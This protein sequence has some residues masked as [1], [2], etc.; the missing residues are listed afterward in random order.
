MSLLTKKIW[1]NY[2]PFLNVDQKSEELY[3]ITESLRQ[4]IEEAGLDAESGKK[5][6]YLLTAE[7]KWVDT[8]GSYFG[9]L[10]QEDEDDETYKRRI[11]WEVTR[12]RQTIEGLKQV[13][14]YYSGIPKNAIGIYEYFIEIQPVDFGAQA[15]E[16]RTVGIEQFNWGVINIITPKQISDDVKRKVEETKAYGIRV[17]YETL[18]SIHTDATALTTNISGTRLH[19]KHKERYIPLYMADYWGLTDDHTITVI[20]DSSFL[21]FLETIAL[22]PYQ[23]AIFTNIHTFNT[24]NTFPYISIVGG[25]KLFSNFY[26]YIVAP[27]PQYILNNQATNNFITQSFFIPQISGAQIHITSPGYGLDPY[28]VISYGSYSEVIKL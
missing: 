21:R 1:R 9:V 11:I 23:E 2:P 18:S 3:T 13:I 15:D 19:L 25:H 5:M 16:T 12:P 14:S 10:R 27:I 7:G 24:E 28:G 20:Y 22:E 6:M 17:F 26:N 4:A 8:W